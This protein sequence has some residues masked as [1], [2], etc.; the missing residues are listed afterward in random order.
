MI[1]KNNLEKVVPVYHHNLNLLT[2]IILCK[3][4]K[5]RIILFAKL[6]SQVE[7]IVP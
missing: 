1:I 4:L 3:I 7:K 2:Q 6:K 5:Y